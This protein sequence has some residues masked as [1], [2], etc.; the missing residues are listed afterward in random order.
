MATN[1]AAAGADATSADSKWT[2]IITID[3]PDMPNIN[4]YKY[5]SKM[6]DMDQTYRYIRFLMVT[7]TDQANGRVNGVSGIP[8]FNLGEFQM[9][10]GMDP[11]RVQYNYNAD[12]HSAVDELKVLLDKYNAYGVHEAWQSDID[13]LQAGLDK[14]LSSYA[15]STEL[16]NLYRS[17]TSYA[18][19]AYVGDEIGTFKEQAPID[20]FVNEIK[21]AR[22]T[23]DQKQPTKISIEAA[24][25]AIKVSYDKLMENMQK[26]VPGQWCKQSHVSKFN[27]YRL[28]NKFWPV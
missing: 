5:T 7:T 27:Q 22:N 1:D 3:E 28:P 23:V 13:I 16:V 12:V 10:T 17:M 26:L 18:A 2:N 24:V 8:Y 21:A 14:L 19:N 9:Y 6:I 20:V 4:A 25:K 15:D 11:E